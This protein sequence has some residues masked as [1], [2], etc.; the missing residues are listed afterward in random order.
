MGVFLPLPRPSDPKKAYLEFHGGSWRVSMA[1]PKAAQR[2]L[3][4]SRLKHNLGTDSLKVANVLKRPHLERFRRRIE[5]ALA[6]VGQLRKD[7]TALALELAKVRK[8]LDRGGSEAELEAFREAVR[9]RHYEIRLKGSRDIFA[10]EDEEGNP[11]F[12]EREQPEQ[13]VKADVF[14][15]IALGRATPVD[16]RF[17]DYHAQLFVKARTKADD[18]R[19]MR[20][21]KEWCLREN[22]PPMLEQI[23]LQRAYAFADDLKLTTG[24]THVTCNKYLGRLAAY[25]QYLGGR[26]PAA[27]QNV[28]AG[29]KLKGQKTKR[30]QK[31]RPFTD[32]E[33][34]TLLMGPAKPHM[35]DLIYIGALT[36]ARLDVIVGLKVCDTENGCL[37]FQPQKQEDTLRFV[38]I[39]PDLA[40]AIAR[41]IAGKGPEDDLFPE[42]PPVRKKG[43]VRE[44]S[45][46][47][48]NHFTDYRRLCG[49][50]HDVPDKRRSLVNFHSFR[51]WF[52]SRLEQ[53]E[54]PANLIAGI[55]GHKNG[56]ITLD[57]YSEGPLMRSARRAVAKVRLPPLD[58]S[59]VREPEILSQRG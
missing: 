33:L 41:R 53:A 16:I 23:D 57:V 8:D 26:V 30:E 5:D 13:I 55:V 21:L 47:T 39:H 24:T 7:D 28:F 9:E 49:V 42:W 58:G 27:R 50:T 35:L 31:E 45:F 2:A 59:P 40:P 18:L 19:A 25:W 54:V 44:R 10:G 6:S 36:G 11:T 34:A 37:R 3:G 43:S 12:V 52:I 20:Y 46:K 29:I 51:R 1:V 14:S 17:E 22:I 4:A 32:R 15:D 38:P 56:T 48:S